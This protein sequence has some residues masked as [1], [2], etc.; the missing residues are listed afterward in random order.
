MPDHVEAPA[1]EPPTIVERAVIGHPLVLA[2]NSSPP[3]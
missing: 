2:S 1:Y 3:T